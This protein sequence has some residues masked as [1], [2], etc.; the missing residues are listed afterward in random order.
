MMDPKPSAL[1]HVHAAF[2]EFITSPM[3]TPSGVS[4]MI[5]DGIRFQDNWR[6]LT[7]DEIAD[8][9]AG[10]RNTIRQIMAQP[11]KRFIIT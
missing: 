5:D 1:D 10:M 4:S 3:L 9:D 6:E 2:G 7:D 8:L 11:E